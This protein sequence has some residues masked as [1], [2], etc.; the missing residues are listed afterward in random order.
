MK[1][2]YE[3]DGME[4]IAAGATAVEATADLELGLRDPL[5]WSII[6][7]RLPVARRRTSS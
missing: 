5:W 6:V 2:I 1:R 4:E 3:R 7:G